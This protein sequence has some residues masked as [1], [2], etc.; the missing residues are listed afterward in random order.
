TLPVGGATRDGSKRAFDLYTFQS[1]LPVGGATLDHVV[2]ITQVSPFQSTLPVGGATA[3]T[4]R[5]LLRF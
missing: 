2:L 5:K 3:K 1:T 4:H